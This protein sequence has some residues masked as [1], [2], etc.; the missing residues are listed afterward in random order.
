MNRQDILTVNVPYI[1]NLTSDG[2]MKIQP[3]AWFTEHVKKFG[4]NMPDIKDFELH[5]IQGE[6]LVYF[7]DSDEWVDLGWTAIYRRKSRPPKVRK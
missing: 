2:G 5:E 3:P 4:D 7:E 1:G 6:R